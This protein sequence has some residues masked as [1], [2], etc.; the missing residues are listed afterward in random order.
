VNR[1]VSN[2]G[3]KQAMNTLD[4]LRV[5]LVQ[6]DTVWH[7]AAANRELYGALV[8]PLRRETDLVVL[9][10]TFTSGFSNEAISDAEDMHGASVAWMRQLAEDT[11]AAITG[12]LVIA[13]AG[14]V[15][16]RLIWAEPDGGLRWYDKRHLFRMADEH[17]RYAGGHSRELWSWRGWRILPQVC[18]DLRFPVFSRNRWLQEEQRAEYDLALYVAN[19]PSPRR[20]AWRTLLRARAIENLA[21]VVGVNRVGTDGNGHAYSGDSAVLD[22]LGMPLLDLGA[23]TQVVT[24][25]LSATLLEA[26]RRR[27]PAFMDADDFS[28]TL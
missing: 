7:D 26:H 13:E 18:Y 6:A 15:V 11:G 3:N 19:W 22:P 2:I 9:P 20:Y 17:L 4:D 14:R 10:E 16:N 25:V 8:R 21:W 28:L 1:V 27:F 23:Q 5:S 12:S 24:T